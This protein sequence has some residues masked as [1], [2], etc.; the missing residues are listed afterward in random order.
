QFFERG[1]S[2]TG[3]QRTLE[4]KVTF[5]IGERGRAP[6]RPPRVRKPCSGECSSNNFRRARFNRSGGSEACQQFDGISRISF[7]VCCQHSFNGVGCGGCSRE[8]VLPL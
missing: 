3:P 6:N 5:V 2:S 7:C 4:Q 8:D 1:L